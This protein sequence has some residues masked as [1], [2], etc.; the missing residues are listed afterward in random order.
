MNSKKI[1]SYI[2]MLVFSAILLIVSDLYREQGLQEAGNILD[3]TANF[4]VHFI[5]VGQGDSILIIDNEDDISIL[6]DGGEKKHG[7]DV[8]KFLRN[9]NIDSLDY[10]VAT[11]PHSDHIGGLI[12]VL[13]T[14]PVETVVM[15]EI[16]HT[17]RTY[18]DFVNSILNNEAETGIIYAKS[19]LYTQNGEFKAQVFA[20]F[21]NTDDL[22]NNS[23]VVRID[24]KDY[25]FLLTGDIEKVV[26]EEILKE[27]FDVNVDIL[28]VAHHGSNTSNSEE[29]LQKV[30][31]YISVI[32]VG[33]DNDYGHPHEEALE[34]I[35]DY[36]EIVYRND[37]NGDISLYFNG[38]GY[39]LN[40][41]K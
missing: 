31:P 20:P 41:E 29:F 19:G 35:N 8:V 21:N 34:I 5:D 1:K 30:S 4:E 27:G 2:Q 33:E 14:F 37:E 38:E 13:K 10:V 18:E 26:E 39:T 25:S 40:T 11:H 16:S 7:D 23:V 17:T 36:S 15:P 12:E 24:Y 3:S 32:Q 9:Q 28:K 22:N 6:V